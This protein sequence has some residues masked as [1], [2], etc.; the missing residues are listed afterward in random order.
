MAPLLNNTYLILK[1]LF[2]SL[3]FMISLSS[4][5]QLSSQVNQYMVYQPLVNFA[6]V[7][8]YESVNAA[9]FYRNQW[10][11]FEGAPITY[12][13]AFAVPIPKKNNIGI[14]N[15][16]VGIAALRNE[17]GIHQ[18][19]ELSINYAYRLQV[20]R[21]SFLSFSLSPTIRFL[22]DN[23]G[24]TTQSE[25]NDPIIN[26]TIVNKTAPNFKF[27]S[28]YF[29]NRFYLGI[30]TS[31]LLYNNVYNNNT[32]YA[33]E[34]GF[35]PK[36][37]NYFLHSGYQFELNNKS[38]LITSGLL[39]IAEGAS[40]HYDLNLMWSYENK[41]GIGVSY[42]STKEI[43]VIANFKLYKQFKLSYAYQHSLSEIAAYENGSH[44]VLFIY[45]LIP[46]KKLIKI[47]TPRF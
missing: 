47:S 17:I 38:D 32:S 21:K 13:L 29:R 41:F 44:E 34:T 40:L 1:L 2:V 37:I 31:N 42:R 11:G 22:S 14:T 3:S 45:E 7:S 43:V 20:N 12:G 46:A 10:T 26:K 6:S 25:N 35:N 5:S 9:M 28:Y 24:M 30:A 39:R 36:K 4:Y 15:S 8:S 19:D 33:V 18:N 27:G 23:Y 16:T